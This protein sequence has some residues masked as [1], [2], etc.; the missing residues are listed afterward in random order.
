MKHKAQIGT[1]LAAG[2]AMMLSAPALGFA[3]QQKMEQT[4]EKPALKMKQYPEDEAGAKKRLSK[5]REVQG[6][7]LDTKTVENRT[8][9]QK[10]L[11]ALIKTQK[12]DKHLVIDFGPAKGQTKKMIRRGA[13]VMAEGPVRQIRGRQFMVARRFKTARKGQK[14]VEI[15]RKKERQQ[16]ER[17]YTEKRASK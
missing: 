2:L 10:N 17:H 5:L 9:A 8:S 15:D 3:Q 13:M 16:F 6:K 14:A 12:G 11:V 1:C 4:K 7:V